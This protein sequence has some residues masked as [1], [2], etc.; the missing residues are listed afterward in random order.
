MAPPGASGGMSAVRLEKCPVPTWLNQRSNSPARSERKATHFPS[1]EISAASSAPSQFV[2]R[3]N[4][5]FASGLAS[6]AGA[7]PRVSQPAA[8]TTRP[9]AAMTRLAAEGRRAES[10]GARRSRLRAGQDLEAECEIARR[11]KPQFARLLQAAR[12]DGD[13]CG[14]HR[15]R[16]RQLRLLLEDG[17]NR[18]GRSLAHECRTTGEHLVEDR[19]DR[20]NV[21]PRVNGLTADLLGRHVA[22]RADHGPGIGF[23]H[24]IVVTALLVVRPGQLGDAEIQNLDPPVGG[25]EQVLGLHIT[26]DDAAVVRCCEPGRGLTREIDRLAPR[27]RALA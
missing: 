26:M 17:G 16:Q 3:M 14:G 22:R 10:A 21:G 6:S 13:K 5:A 8:A 9:S 24:R 1:G 7:A 19:P 4:S 11:L 2:K 27:E 15:V 20:K 18:V 23:G 25:D 12:H